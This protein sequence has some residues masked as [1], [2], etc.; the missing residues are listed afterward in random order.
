MCSEHKEQSEQVQYPATSK[1]QSARTFRPQRN[2]TAATHH[3]KMCNPLKG[4]YLKAAGQTKNAQC[5]Q[6]RG[7]RNITPA[8]HHVGATHSVSRKFSSVTATE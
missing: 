3:V 7:M 4:V 8:K 2:V 5:G 6:S 1:T